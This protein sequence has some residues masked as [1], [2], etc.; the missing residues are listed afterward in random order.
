[1]LFYFF[2]KNIFCENLI[3]AEKT[4]ACKSYVFHYQY[5]SST[6]A[7]NQAHCPPPHPSRK[8]PKKRCPA[9]RRKKISL[10]GRTVRGINTK[11]WA[12]EEKSHKK[13]TG[14]T[15]NHSKSEKRHKRA[16]TILTWFLRSFLGASK[17]FFWNRHSTHRIV[18]VNRWLPFSSLLR[19]YNNGFRAP[20]CLVHWPFSGYIGGGGSWGNENRSK[21]RGKGQ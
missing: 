14:K 16:Y 6:A 8:L 11:L 15:R 1:M 10:L 9:G 7:V 20:S 17:R 12:T 19:R 5:G 18:C 13:Y 4:G 21:K 2:K 3:C